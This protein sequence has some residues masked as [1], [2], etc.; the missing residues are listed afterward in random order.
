MTAKKIIL[1]L[2][3]NPAMDRSRSVAV[4]TPNDKLNCGDEFLQA[5]GGGLNVSRV[6]HE[7]GGSSSAFYT[8]GGPT[9]QML[10]RLLNQIGID[11]QPLP[12]KGWTR[13]CF[14]VLE[15]STQQEYRF[16]CPGPSLEEK[17]W[18]SIL[19]RCL[20]RI[21][22]TAIVVASGSLP[23]EVPSTFYSDLNKLV[24]KKGAEL[25]LDCS[26]LAL[27]EALKSKV[28][29]IKPNLHEL[30]ELMGDPL[31]TDEQ[32]ENAVKSLI[33]DNRCGAVVLSR[34][35]AGAFVSTK[36]E[37]YS[38]NSPNVP[39]VSAVGAGD[40]MVAGIAYKLQKGAGFLEAATFG[41]ATGARAVAKQHRDIL[42]LSVV[43][44][45]ASRCKVTRVP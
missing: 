15:K 45:L 31:E 30:R 40:S 1:T 37:S 11:H 13:E 9:G 35:A 8:S 38:L 5:G 44:S 27:K 10:E 25:I 4:L 24:I 6:I 43:E 22:P 29:L 17:E 42:D 21:S 2:T 3:L 7:L 41:V 39:F 19:D 33:K 18:L 28:F 26:G 34:G 36:N 14:V 23:P 20:D 12:V 32:Q 16:D